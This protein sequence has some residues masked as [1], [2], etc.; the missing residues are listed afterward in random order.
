MKNNRKGFTLVEL[1]I[2]IA[3]I[4]I[5]AGVIIGTFA[6]VVNRAKES[7]KIQEM[8]NAELAQKAEDI[9]KKIDDANWYGWEDFETSIV[10]K[11][12]TVIS[13]AKPENGEVKVEL[14]SEVVEKAV[15]QAMAKYYAENAMANTGLT[16]AQ[17]KAIVE[18]AFGTFKYEGVS[19]EQV[20][21]IVNVAVARIA[22]L[23]VTQVQR[24]V[25]A[26]VAR[27]EEGQLSAAQIATI[28]SNALTTCKTD[29]A[30]P[31]NVSSAVDQVISAINT[32]TA[33]P[34]TA[35]QVERI[36]AAAVTS[37][38]S[39]SWIDSQ[40]Y[41]EDE[42]FELATPEDVRGLATLVNGGYD[43][44]GKEIT[45]P[46][47]ID[48]STSGDWT[49]IGNSYDTQFEGTL[50]G[51]EGG[52]VIDGLTLTEQF[53][54]V[55][56]GLLINCSSTGN[57]DKVGVGF[58][59]YLGEGAVLENITFTNVNINI[60]DDRM[61][62]ISVGVA[63][64][65]LDGGTIKNVVVAS[66]SIKAPYRVGGLVGAA[67]KGSIVDCTVA[68]GVVIASTG[69]KLSN[70]GYYC[71]G[72]LVGYLRN[73]EDA[74]SDKNANVVTVSGTTVAT[75]LLS[76]AAGGELWTGAHEAYNA[77]LEGFTNT[78]ITE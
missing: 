35:E 76:S 50:V 59:A 6:S 23:S 44:A 40:S 77:K 1:V 69:T 24:I 16:E 7:A 26:A 57:M 30:T 64:G 33:N 19:A 46:E 71:V 38:G 29:L 45:L 58:V 14:D 70:A 11:I 28:V 60:T 32:A 12:A 3:V 5:F 21:T 4:A 27:V 62:G 68:S 22:P 39:T 43:F 66:G 17:V 18:N 15:S 31:A 25:E 13:N 75:T 61:D 53:N 51:A 56:N 47:E 20:S 34:L 42:T 63:V 41:A 36:I 65:Y 10:E 52:T 37:A 67:A 8:K 78:K 2:V 73:F 48:L 54:A 55:K 49:P 9:L 72:G 74:G